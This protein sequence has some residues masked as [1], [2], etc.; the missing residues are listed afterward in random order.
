MPSR[1]KHEERIHMPVINA[2]TRKSL[3][4]PCQ[5]CKKS[6][7][8]EGAAKSHEAIDHHEEISRKLLDRIR[9]Q[10]TYDCDLCKGIYKT[11]TEQ[12]L[13]RHYRIVHRLEHQE[14]DE[15]MKTARKV[16]QPEVPESTVRERVWCHTD[17]PSIHEIAKSV[18]LSAEVTPFLCSLCRR[19]FRTQHGYNMHRY[20]EHGI[21][22]VKEEVRVKV[23]CFECDFCD[24][25]FQTDA[26]KWLHHAEVHEA[27]K[28]KAYDCGMCE[29]VYASG[30]EL[31]KHWK[32]VHRLKDDL[33]AKIDL[34]D[35]EVRGRAKME[36]AR[37]TIR[38]LSQVRETKFRE[39]D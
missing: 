3:D 17:K 28:N 12:N 8:T 7:A 11:P 37:R 10:E 24:D 27:H 21:K 19:A 39:F 15:R 26:A 18:D 1:K 6:F 36:K 33:I 25:Q 5:F 16:C 20:K 29:S 35:H 23:R 13:R 2:E 31:R 4:Y 30:V 34:L 9:K 38:K 14:I 32:I 22:N